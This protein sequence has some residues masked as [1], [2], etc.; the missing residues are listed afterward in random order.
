MSATSRDYLE[1]FLDMRRK[2]Q[3]AEAVFTEQQQKDLD[4]LL[5]HTRNDS[6]FELESSREWFL[7]LLAYALQKP[8]CEK[9]AFIA[10]KK[11]VAAE[12]QQGRYVAKADILYNDDIPGQYPV[13]VR[14]G[15]RSDFMEDFR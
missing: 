2:T 9:L 1:Q 15:Q 6:P 12:R 8:Y 4:P 7:D 13:I 14:E 3:H 11:I 5:A 10:M